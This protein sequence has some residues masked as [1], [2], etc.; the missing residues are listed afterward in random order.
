MSD[1][2]VAPA[3][4]A[5]PSTAAKPPKTHKRRVKWMRSS[6]VINIFADCVIVLC[7]VM[8]VYITISTVSE[9][10][11][12]NKVMP[13]SVIMALFACWDG[14]LLIIML[15]QVLGSDI[16]QKARGYQLG[17][18]MMGYSDYSDA[19]SITDETNLSV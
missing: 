7:L 19:T 1:T 10:H 3:I 2:L 11:R 15:R 8:C 6:K 17:N 5:T 9:Y 4:E 16:V 12:L 13:A 14:E 18:S